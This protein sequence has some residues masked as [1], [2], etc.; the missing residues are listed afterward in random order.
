MIFRVLNSRYFVWALLAWPAVGMT[1]FLISG[2]MEP[3]DKL[4]MEQMLHPTGEFSARFMI[5]A[6]MCTPLRMLFPQS[7]FVRWLMK[8]RRYFGVA[9]FMYALA[10]TIFYIL[11]MQFLYAIVDEFW[12]ASIWTGWLAFA[13]FI[14]L[15]LTSNNAAVKRLGKAW[16]SLQRWVYPAAVATLVHWILVHNNWGP[17]LVHF[18]PLAALEAYRI[19][20]VYFSPTHQ[21]TPAQ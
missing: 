6:M 13:I 11:D 12:I 5:V 8:N 4:I 2:L 21:R 15:V 17:A 18:V 7:R 16:K 19:W 3:Y 14:P 10:H 9:A 20:R 1:R